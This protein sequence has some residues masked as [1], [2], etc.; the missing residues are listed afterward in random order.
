MID[1]QR[2]LEGIRVLVTRPKD[3]SRELVFLLE[4]EGAQV[5]ALPLLE[6]LPPDD[7]RP[8]R[9]A[10]EQIHRYGWVLLASPSAAQALVEAVRQAGTFDQL[11][12]VKVATVGPATA[13]AAQGMGLVV[14]LQATVGS[15]MGLF[16]SVQ[17]ALGPQDEVLLPAAQAGRRELGDALEDAGVKVDRVAAYQSARSTL[18]PAI[19]NELE[20]FEPQVVIFGSPRTAEAF[21]EAT[22]EPGRARLNQAKLVAIGPTTAAALVELGLAPVVAARPTAPALVDAAAQALRS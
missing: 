17:A 12:K 20:A 2:R 7:P 16:E 15:G 18:E 4:D 9:A 21:L 22:G 1:A 5:M 8:L 6:L 11:T 13:K 19:L 3:R 14:A 10:A